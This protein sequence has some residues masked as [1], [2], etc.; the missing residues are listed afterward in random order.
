MKRDIVKSNGKIVMRRLLRSIENTP[1]LNQPG[2]PR[3]VLCGGLIQN[4]TLPERPLRNTDQASLETRFVPGQIVTCSQ[5]R[6]TKVELKLKQWRNGVGGGSYEKLKT[7]PTHIP[8]DAVCFG[9]RCR[10]RSRSYCILLVLPY[11]CNM[12]WTNSL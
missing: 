12:S 2:P 3:A 8:C 1:R 5:Q 9:L 4:Q 6:R 7:C 10:W 11:F